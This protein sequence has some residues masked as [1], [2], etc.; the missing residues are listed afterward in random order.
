M[1]P[2]GCFHACAYCYARPSHEYW[3]F[4]L[5]T[6]FESKIVPKRRAA[7]LLQQAFEK[8]SWKG[9]LVVFLGNTDCYNPRGQELGDQGLS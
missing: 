3:G 8:P 4:E 5:G 6:D 2:C 9:E 1:N 7:I